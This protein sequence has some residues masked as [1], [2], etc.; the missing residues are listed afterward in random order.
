VTNNLSFVLVQKCEMLT[1]HV[2]R[3]VTV[4]ELQVTVFHKVD[5]VKTSFIGNSRQRYLA[6]VFLPKYIIT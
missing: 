4:T 2:T 3:E 5:Y 1:L 6:D